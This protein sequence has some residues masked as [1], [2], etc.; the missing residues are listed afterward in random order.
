MKLQEFKGDCV[1]K[2]NGFDIPGVAHVIEVPYRDGLCFCNFVMQISLADRSGNGNGQAPIGAAELLY[3]GRKARI[4]IGPLKGE[5][6]Y[7]EV[8]G[9]G[10][11][12]LNA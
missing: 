12:E 1:L 11:V 4:T 5:E 7:M 6:A 9:A 3:D 10:H 8:A 2:S